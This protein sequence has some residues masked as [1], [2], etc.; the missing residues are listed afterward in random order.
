[1]DGRPWRMTP[2]TIDNNFARYSLN[3]RVVLALS[4]FSGAATPISTTLHFTTCHPCNSRSVWASFNIRKYCQPFSWVPMPKS[5]YC[6]NT[7]STSFMYTIA[8]LTTVALGF[9]FLDKGSGRGWASPS[10][11]LLRSI[12]IT[13]LVVEG[14]YTDF[15]SLICWLDW[16]DA[17][18]LECKPRFT[19]G[20]CPSMLSKEI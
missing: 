10:A 6:V 9:L 11:P 18:Q 20:I 5:W 19:A 3:T 8:Y 17:T 2:V 13:Y 14:F 7:R 16:S 4:I 1:M 15:H 12:P